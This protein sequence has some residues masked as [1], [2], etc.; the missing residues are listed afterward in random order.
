MIRGRI[1]VGKGCKQIITDSSGLYLAVLTPIQTVQMFEVGIGRKI[2][3]FCPQLKKV[4]HFMFSADSK[5]FLIFNK[6]M[7]SVKRYAIDHRLSNLSENV[8][9]GMNRDPN[10]WSNFPI[11]LD[12]QIPSTSTT[13]QQT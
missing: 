11:H 8:L 3:E 5:A 4:G 6:E 10:F 12:Q 2:Y 13:N 7:I 9:L 1:Q